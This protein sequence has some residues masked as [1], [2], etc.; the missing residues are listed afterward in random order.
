MD[1]SEIRYLFNNERRN[2]SFNGNYHAI[3]IKDEAT[4][5]PANYTRH[6][7]KSNRCNN[8]IE[9]EKKKKKKKKEGISTKLLK[10]KLQQ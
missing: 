7:T 8:K 6:K 10:E 4:R 5:Q 9:R 1:K 2:I 3:K